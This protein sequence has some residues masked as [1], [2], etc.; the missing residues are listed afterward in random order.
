MAPWVPR[1]KVSTNL[2]PW[3]PGARETIQPTK[4]QLEPHFGPK[5]QHLAH[6]ICLGHQDLCLGSQ[7]PLKTHKNKIGFKST[8]LLNCSLKE[9]IIILELKPKQPFPINSMSKSISRA[10]NH[11]KR[12]LEIKS[13]HQQ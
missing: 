8:T 7:R 10:L 2:L 6:A 3:A 9:K 5:T 13:N 11:K 4:L 1:A 12:V